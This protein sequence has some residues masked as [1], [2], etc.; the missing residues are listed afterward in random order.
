MRYVLVLV[1]LVLRSTT[2]STS[3]STA[4]A[5]T[6]GSVLAVRGANSIM[7]PSA[8][9]A[10]REWPSRAQQHAILQ[11]KKKCSLRIQSN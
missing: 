10:Q 4:S 7:W 11:P 2:S 6:C 3:T 8:T 5:G 1:V 9:L